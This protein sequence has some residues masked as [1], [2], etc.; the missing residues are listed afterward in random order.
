MALYCKGSKS[1]KKHL[2]EFSSSEVVP[3]KVP[4]VSIFQYLLSESSYNE[5]MCN[6]IYNTKPY[7]KHGKIYSYSKLNLRYKLQIYK[8]NISLQ[9]NIVFKQIKNNEQMNLPLPL[10]LSSAQLQGCMISH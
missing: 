7:H 1:G 2:A 3:V 5:S 4:L 10:L 9:I 6:S 8:T